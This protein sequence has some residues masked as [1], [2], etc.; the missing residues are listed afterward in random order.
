MSATIQIKFV[1]RS[2]GNLK[3]P[4]KYRCII[5][6]LG[7]VLLKWDQSGAN[8][9]SAAQ[10]TVLQNS[11]AWHDLDRGKLSLKDACVK[12]GEMLGLAPSLIEDASVEVQRS[13]VADHQMVQL[14]LDLRSE[15]PDLKLYVMSNIS[16]E[17]YDIVRE[18]VG[19][20]WDLFA[21]CFASGHEGMRKP[22]LAFFQHVVNEIGGYPRE[23]IFVDDSAENICAARSLGIQGVL[24]EDKMGIHDSELWSLVQ[25][26]SLLRA[27]RFMNANA[28]RHDSIV[29]GQ[30][31]LRLRDNFAQLMIWEL[32]GDE[33]LVYL[34]YPS[35]TL[36]DP[37]RALN[38][39]N[40]TNGDTQDGNGHDS[41]SDLIGDGLWNYLC[42]IPPSTTTKTFPLNDA[43]TTALA[44]LSFPTTRLYQ[45]VAR[46]KQVL[47]QMAANLDPDGLMQTYFS[48]ECPRTVPEA[49]CNM[50]RLFHRLGHGSGSDPR[51]R[52]TEEYLVQCVENGA[53]RYGSGKYTDPE[54][55]LYFA[56]KLH[57]E[58][59]QGSGGGK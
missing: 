26:D 14:M 23:M 45:H 27:V 53:C 13:F 51:I 31:G 22:E 48:A 9:L 41:S 54:S 32:T 46:M 18:N 28:G 37:A 50:L 59:S 10:L 34:R 44:Y 21:R 57:N 20:P 35:G 4:R 39:A 55:L 3:M 38:G 8:D 12:F 16:K 19:L 43:D 40:T 56:A 33:D 5:F 6:D 42:E 15:D 24:V 11:T 49:C 47:D 2:V 29:E 7:G 58:C 52:R 25:P 30:D 36:H 1:F 17:H